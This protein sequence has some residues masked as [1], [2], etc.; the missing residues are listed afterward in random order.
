MTMTGYPNRLGSILTAMITP[1]TADGKS[2]DEEGVRRLL[3]HLADNG[4]DGVVIAGTTGEAPTL[5]DDEQVALV[6]LAVDEISDRMTVIAGAGSNDTRH[7]VHLTERTA[8]AGADAIL[9][10]TPYYN[11]PNVSGIH[12]HFSAVAGATDL[13]VILYNIPAR[14]GTDMTDDLIREIGERNPTVCAIKQ[15]RAGDPMPIEG[16]D[17]YAGNDDSFAAALDN[18]AAGGILVASHIVGKQMK[19]M[20]DDPAGRAKI[21]KELRPLYEALSVTTNPIPIKC[22][23][24]IL[25]LPS[26]GLRLPLVPCDSTEELSIRQTLKSLGIL[27]PS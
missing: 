18:G 25:G 6:E 13:P 27:N 26:G 11:R 20:V 10:V 14:T 7:A 23:L 21:D 8:E 12:E 5:S 22:A 2:V 17:L 15:A 3:N 19:S 1:F 9:T 16:L 24:E 4:S